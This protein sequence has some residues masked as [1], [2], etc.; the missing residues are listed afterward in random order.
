MMQHTPDTMKTADTPDSL[1]SLD[2]LDT[3]NTPDTSADRRRFL[4]LGAAAVAL[5]F[6]AAARARTSAS[7]SEITGW[8]AIQLSQAIQSRR[9]SCVEVM[10]AYLDQIDRLN[11]KVNALVSLQPREALLAQAAQ[12]DGQLGR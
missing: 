2:T 4:Q 6:G 10:T 1:D 7:A 12:R 3:P 8:T 9:V 11:P 5:P